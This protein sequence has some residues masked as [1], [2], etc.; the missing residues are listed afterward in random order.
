MALNQNSPVLVLYERRPPVT[1][2]D[3]KSIL[4]LKVVQSVGERAP[5]LRDQAI[6]RE[7]S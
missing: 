1:E 2:R 3:V 4:L 5:V 6:A 7:S